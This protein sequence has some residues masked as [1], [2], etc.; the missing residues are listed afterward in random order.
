MTENDIVK[1]LAKES[2]T[3]RKLGEEHRLLEEKLSEF[4]G[5]IYLTPDEEMEKKRVQ[6]LK[7][8]KKDRMAELIRMYKQ[9]HPMN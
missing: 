4:Q 8:Q 9:S 7:L 3:F 2:E 1:T 5:R 6:K